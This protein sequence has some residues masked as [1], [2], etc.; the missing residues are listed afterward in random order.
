M[1]DA[2]GY[3]ERYLHGRMYES[4]RLGWKLGECTPWTHCSF[5]DKYG[6]RNNAWTNL[7]STMRMTSTLPS[8]PW[9]YTLCIWFDPR[10]SG[11]YGAHE[12]R[13]T[14]G[15]VSWIGFDNGTRLRPY[16][17]PTVP[18]HGCPSLTNLTEE[19]YRLEKQR[20]IKQHDWN[21]LIWPDR[22]YSNSD[23]WSI[24][25]DNFLQFP[26]ACF[27]IRWNRK[28]YIYNYWTCKACH[29]KSDVMEGW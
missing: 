17:A 9:P 20:T 13:V 12:G 18:V 11:S 25:F 2:R 6:F 3:V 21:T 10:A 26:I 24:W 29:W 27:H 15:P 4:F 22:C 16:C 19:Q 14:H 8:I 1:N 28:S 7:K 23:N 5:I